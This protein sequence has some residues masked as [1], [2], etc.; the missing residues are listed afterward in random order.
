MGPTRARTGDGRAV[1]YAEAE[2]ALL[3]LPRFAVE[4]RTALRPGLERM[5]ALCAAMGRPE[6][7]YPVVH[8]AGTN[9]KGSTA[10]MVAA[11][12]TAAGQRIG[13]HTSPH[14]FRLTERMRVDGVPAPPEWVADAVG[15][16][17]A[18]LEA[19]RPSFFEATAALSLLYFAE[20]GVDRAVVEVGLGGRLDAT[21][22]VEPELAL[23]TSIGLD[24]TD[25]LGETLVE[26]AGEKAGIIKP[27]VPA[28]TSADQPDVV[29]RLRAAAAV[30]GSVLGVAGEDFSGTVEAVYPDRIVLSVHTAEHMYEAVT[31]G[32]PGAHQAENA[33]LAV[34]AAEAVYGAAAEAAIRE[35]LARVR[36]LS[37]LRG[38]CEIVSTEPPIVAD[39]AHNAEGLAAALRFAA[40]LHSPGTGRLYVVFGVM[41]D[42]PLA[43]LLDR[44]RVSG[45][46]VLPVAASAPRALPVSDL[47]AALRAQHIPVVGVGSVS[48]GIRWFRRSAGSQDVLLITGSHLTVADVPASLLAR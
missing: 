10:S 29:A 42:K 6:R 12:G 32:L 21:N 13:L 34:A 2:A 22:V 35:G 15:R 31:V 5:R 19:I 46:T 37:G 39:V 45:A 30:Q 27:G 28:L 16:F 7:A 26:I 41:R 36:E 14:L 23:I 9:G 25:L 47:R 40:S 20:R 33:V 4:G 38:R 1:T 8:V 24:H 17:R 48:E 44:L 3:A 11:V 18:D 43:S